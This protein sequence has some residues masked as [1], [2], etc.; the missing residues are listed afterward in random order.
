VE[1]RHPSRFTTA[2]TARWRGRIYNAAIPSLGRQRIYRGQFGTAAFQSGHHSG[3]HARDLLHQVGM[4]I[5]VLF[6]ATLPVGLLF[7]ALF[8]LPIAATA[9]VVSLGMVDLLHATPPRRMRNDRLRF[10]LG[11]AVMHLLQPVV[12]SWARARARPVAW[13]DVQRPPKLPR[14]C[15]SV[16]GVL[17]F[18][19][20]RPR[21]DLVASIIGHLRVAGARV[22]LATGWDDYDAR[23]L[24]SRLVVGD[25]VTS[26]HPI[27]Y[28]QI[29]VRRRIL[30]R[31]CLGLASLILMLAV[32]DTSAAFGVGAIGAVDA[33]L[34]VWR[35]GP[36]VRRKL[37][38][39]GVAATCDA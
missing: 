29:A 7:N 3:S 27:G 5:A 24:A 35:T 38:S 12:R 17:L 30:H 39:Q 10:R 21:A 15:R 20:D 23:L 6:M 22:E 25:L 32:V 26:S 16:R 14:V 13:R 1:A 9:F 18:E 28:V 19:A 33:L 4:P 8:A 34:G 2:G 31:R 37:S 11:V 36:S